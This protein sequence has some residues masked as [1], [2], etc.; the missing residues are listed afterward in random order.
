MTANTQRNAVLTDE[1]ELL[2]AALLDLAV[3]TIWL[4]ILQANSNT[5]II[6]SIGKP[7]KQG[8]DVVEF[9]TKQA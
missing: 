4:M 9:G 3:A 8:K 6:K 7:L 5:N 2:G 1:F